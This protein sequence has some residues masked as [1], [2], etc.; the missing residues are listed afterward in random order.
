MGS[1]AKLE[2]II[3]DVARSCSSLVMEC[4][5]VGGHVA[6]VSER[7]DQRV[8]Q[9]DRL[10]A[11]TGAL[12][13]DQ[14]RVAAAIDQSQNLS[15][16]IK[17]K[18]TQGRESIIESVAGFSDVTDLVVRLGDRIER[19][20]DAL[21]QVEQVSQMIGGIAQQTN[22]LALNAAIEAARAG[23]AGNAFAVV[24]TEVKKLAQNT[25]QATQRINDTIATLADEAGIF[26]TEIRGGVEQSKSAAA[27]FAAIESTVQDIGSIV[28]LVDEQAAGIS[29][30][31]SE[32]HKSIASVRAEMVSAAWSV[33]ANDAALRD[34]RKRLER[35]ESVG[36]E[37]L[38]QLAGSGIEIDDSRSIAIAQQIAMEITTLVESAVR[39]GTLR[40]EAI[41][42]VDYQPMPGT[43][44]IQYMTGFNAFADAHIRPILDRVREEDPMAIGSVVT[45]LNGYLPTHLSLRSQ[46]QGRDVEWNNTWSRNRR[47]L[48]DDAT[49]RAIAS[50]APFMLNCYRMTL[51]KGEFLL[52]KS[53]FVPLRFNDRRWGNY[54]YAYL[55]EFTA[56]ADLISPEALAASLARVRD[57][58]SS[59][60]D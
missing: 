48:M 42:D 47:I 59:S 44:P 19:I 13:A 43:N 35:L 50:E 15:H 14:R 5:D 29:H 16:D 33:R 58:G 12:A 54:E 34:A 10:D 41:F 49:R 8:T 30:S 18:L 17:E 53:V 4:A 11:V 1:S 52:L 25:R 51:G 56:T 23:E 26:G 60:T 27:K 28:Y 46:P 32:M 36:N 3:S 57:S 7:M 24:A 55:D 45:D 6:G 38:D 22:M 37:M 31:A 20:I 21:G 40:M 9:I 2:R 39:S